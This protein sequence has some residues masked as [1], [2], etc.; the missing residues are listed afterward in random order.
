MKV[1]ELFIDEE[2]EFSGIDAISIVEQP[3][4]EENFI[5][6]KEDIKVEL[7]DVDKEKRI[8][9]GA[10]LIPNKKIYRRNGEE[11]FYIYFSE[12]TVRKASEMFLIKGNQ[13]KSTLEHQAELSGM[14]V[15]ESWIIEDDKYDKSRKYGLKMPIGTWMVSMK[16][17]NEDVW[18]DYV[19]TG[20]VKGFSIEGYFT[21]KVAMSMIQQ[22]EDA[23]EILLEIADS[24]E[25]GKLNLK[26][27]GDYGSGVRNNAKRGIELNKK[28]NNR[29]ATSVGKIRAQQLARGEKLSVS[30]IK[31]MYSYLSRA[32]EYYD[33]SDS[34]ACGTISYLLWGG[35]AGLAWSRGKLRELGEIELAEYDD[36]GRIKS[37]PKAP[38]SD[39]ANPNPKRGSSRNRKSAAGRSGGVNVPDRVL[40]SLQKK[41]DDFNDKYK[42]EKGYGT[43][44]G[45]LK[46][47]YQRGVGA[48]QTSHSP[49]VKSAEQWGQARVNAYIYLLK[50]G[51]PQ[52][53]KYTTD[54]DL[55]PKKHPKSS[56]K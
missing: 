25:T 9:M 46:S 52:N 28:V 7:A 48:F 30:T 42:S 41:A 2:G 37:S 35:K 32:S 19:K 55:L 44:V 11:E 54:Y 29:C 10:A 50:N 47:V 33:P 18:K 16:V 31:R 20:K 17:N 21:D 13:N 12:D 34:K 56:K 6:L 51:R 1:I 23:A 26:T 4:I 45:Q 27:Y 38:K 14:S 39:T 15:V 8:L 49:E 43:T 40:K 24:I 3:A 36:K 22:E 5:A 53:D